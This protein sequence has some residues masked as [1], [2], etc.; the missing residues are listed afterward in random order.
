MDYYFLKVA[1]CRWPILGLIKELK[2]LGPFLIALSSADKKPS[3]LQKYL[4]Q[5]VDEMKFRKKWY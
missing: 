1:S 2:Q 4:S 5:F 3:S